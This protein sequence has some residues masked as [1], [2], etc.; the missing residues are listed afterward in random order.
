MEV[1]VLI[2]IE[3]FVRLRQLLSFLIWQGIIAFLIIYFLCSLRVKAC[4]AKSKD[5]RETKRI[6]HL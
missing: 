2:I 1:I 6:I 5:V 4:L 3:L